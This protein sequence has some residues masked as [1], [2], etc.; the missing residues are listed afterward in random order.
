[1]D[2]F[3]YFYSDPKCLARPSSLIRIWK[4]LNVFYITEDKK[5]L[6]HNLVLTYVFN[7]KLYWLVILINTVS[8]EKGMN[9]KRQ[10]LDSNGRPM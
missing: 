7:L 4:Y 8:Q 9:W 3:W 6:G 5:I 10:T 1:M 2:L